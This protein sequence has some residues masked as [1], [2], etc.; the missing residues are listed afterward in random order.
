[1][2]LLALDYN[3]WNLLTVRKVMSSGSFKN[4]MYRLFV[5][6]SFIFDTCMYKI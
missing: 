3:T 5:F 6:K 4:V 1:M 2:E